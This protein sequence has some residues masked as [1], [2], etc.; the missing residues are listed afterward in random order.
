MKINFIPRNPAG[1]LFLGLGQILFGIGTVNAQTVPAAVEME[2]KLSSESQNC[3][4]DAEIIKINQKINE[5]KVSLKTQNKLISRGTTQVLFDWPLRQSSGFDYKSTWVISNYIDHDLSSALLDWNCQERTYDT[6]KGIDIVLWPFMWKQMD[7]EQTEIVAAAEGQIIY[8]QD[9]YFDR[10]CTWNSNPWNA[11]YVLHA[12][13]SEAWYGHMKNGSTTSKVVGDMVTRGEF[14]GFVGSSG[15]STAP[16][17][18]LQIYDANN[19]LIDPYNGNCNNFSSWWTNQEP[20]DNPHINA[21]LTHSAPPDFGDCPE[22]EITNATNHFYPNQQIFLTSYYRDVQP[23]TSAIV[24]L[25]DPLGNTI[26]NRSLYM[27][28]FYSA[29]YWYFQAYLTDAEGVWTYRVQYLDQTVDHS[30]NVGELG[31]QDYSK[32]D[33][34]LYPNPA[35]NLLQIDNPQHHKIETITIYNTL[36][37]KVRDFINPSESLDVSSLTEGMY[38]LKIRIGDRIQVLNLLKK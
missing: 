16:H 30:F 35:Q 2:F 38:Y 20:Y 34:S 36:G 31:T 18:H 7:D 26:L 25:I 32:L 17:L 23:G 28:N 11:V 37:Q 3:I 9:G 33:L 10:N 19:N 29:S 4:S 13:G 12:D 14:L 5:N 8:K 22:T 6:H 24:T 1:I 21:I 15:S 27:S